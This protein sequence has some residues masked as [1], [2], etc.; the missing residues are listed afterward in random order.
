MIARF[1]RT[2]PAYGEILATYRRPALRQY[3]CS[4][5]AYEAAYDHDL[6]WDFRLVI[7]QAKLVFADLIGGD[8]DR[9]VLPAAGPATDAH[10]QG[11]G[12]PG[13]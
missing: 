3:A 5:R 10:H 7:V 9:W 12:E 11:P 6:L 2:V 8:Q 4:M 1:D 13:V